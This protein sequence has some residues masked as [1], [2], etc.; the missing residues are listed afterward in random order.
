MSL[1]QTSTLFDESDI[2]TDN[3]MSSEIEIDI[4]QH[5]I[6]NQRVLE[7]LEKITQREEDEEF[8]TLSGITEILQQVTPESSFH[9][10]QY[11]TTSDSLG[12]VVNSPFM[13]KKMFESRRST[14]KKT[15]TPSGSFS[16]SEQD[17]R[18]NSPLALMSCESLINGICSACGLEVS[19]RPTLTAAGESEY[20]DFVN[21]VIDA[22][23]ET[24]E[25]LDQQ[26]FE[27][28][29]ELADKDNGPSDGFI[30]KLTQRL[31]MYKEKSA[32]RPITSINA[33]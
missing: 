20:L 13:S 7:A 11:Q 21:K 33:Q 15:D 14:V 24:S 26:I 22:F 17:D 8:E 1:L 5:R 9:A 28:Q 16:I 19:N 31:E 3:E 23:G 29:S 27:L 10:S 25:H 6:A 12:Q 4:Q 18:T 2:S 32:R 30:E